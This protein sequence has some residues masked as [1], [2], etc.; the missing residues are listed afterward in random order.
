MVSPAFIVPKV[1]AA[2]VQAYGDS[3]VTA[4][5]LA[6]TEWLMIRETP[7]IAISIHIK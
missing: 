2:E 4:V 1:V 3:D 5:A 7:P 6:Q